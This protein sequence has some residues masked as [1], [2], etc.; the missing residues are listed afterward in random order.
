MPASAFELLEF[1]VDLCQTL[2]KAVSY[3][4]ARLIQRLMGRPRQGYADMPF[5]HGLGWILL[6]LLSWALFLL[7]VVLLIIQIFK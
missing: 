6:D 5:L 3:S 2:Y 4:P 1:L 7:L